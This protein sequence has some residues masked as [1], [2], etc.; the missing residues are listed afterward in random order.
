MRTAHL[1][2]LVLLA[3]CAYTPAE[4]QALKPTVTFESAQPP[5][6]VAQCLGR[7]AEE[8]KDP[9]GEA[10]F[11]ARW[12][13]AEKPGALEVIITGGHFTFAVAQ[14]APT[15][16]GSHATIWQSPPLVVDLAEIMAR[17]C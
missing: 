11:Q 15:A 10:R 17:G 6:K 4:L 16:N 3:G 2:A 8:S 1:V 12:R 5:L 9:F 14:V 13:E 7:N